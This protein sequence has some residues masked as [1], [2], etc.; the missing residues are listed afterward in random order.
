[1]R[2]C[3]GERYPSQAADRLRR[4]VHPG[5]NTDLVTQPRRLTRADGG[6]DAWCGGCESGHSVDSGNGGSLDVGQPALDA[7]L[8]PHLPSSDE[9][10]PQG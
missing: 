9:D 5:D 1:M 2:P 10:D 4:G 6:T 7:A 3:L 8:L